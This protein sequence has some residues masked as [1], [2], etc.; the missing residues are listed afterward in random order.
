[1]EGGEVAFERDARSVLVI[2][3]MVADSVTGFWPVCNP[4][5]LVRNVNRVRDA[6][7]RA[8]IP[9][10][11]LQHTNRRDGINTMLGEARDASGRPLACVEGTPGWQIVAALDPGD[12][13]VVV[14]KSRWHGFFGTELLSVLHGLRAEQLVWVGGFTDCCLGLSVFEGYANDYPCALIADAA[15]CTTAFIHKTAVLTMANWI[16]DLSIFT[17]DRF[18]QWLRGEDVPVWYAGR[19]NT[20]PFADEHDVELHYR[21]ILDGDS[22]QA[23]SVENRVS[24]RG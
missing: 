15:S 6:C 23:N 18:E 22:P 2:V 20:L 8:G 1:M 11:Q 24:A 19:H 5:E 9:V 13:D 14:R 17:T 7:Y 16:Y 3:D 12:T 4:D 10:V 21:A